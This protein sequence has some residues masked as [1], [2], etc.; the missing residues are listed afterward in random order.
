MDILHLIKYSKSY[1]LLRRYTTF[2]HS[3]F[4][5]EICVINKEN[6]PDN[7]PVIFAPNHQN[8]LMD[9][10]AIICTLKK[11]P[12]FMARADIFKKKAI[13]NLLYFFKI[14]P[15]YRIRDGIDQLQNNDDSF[16]IAL[17]VL[18]NNNCV[19]IMP[20]GN[21]GDQRRLRPLK[22][23]LSRFALQVQEKFGKSNSLKIIPV[24][25]EYSHYKKFRSKILVIY[26]N[27]IE[28]ADFM[29]IYMQSPQKAMNLLRD[30]LNEEMKSNIIN[31]DTD[32]YYDLVCILTDMY[33]N[34]LKIKL[35]AGNSF[36]EEYQV[37]KIISDK[38]VSISKT[39]QE[40]LEILLPIVNEYRSGL[41]KLHLSDEVFDMGPFNHKN[42]Y[43]D[44]I[45]YSFFLPFAVVGTLFHFLPG[46]I[47]NFLSGRVK[48]SQFQSSVKFVLYMILFPLYYIIVF[49][50]RIP[51]YTKIIV[52]LLMPVLG[53]LSFDYAIALKRCWY[54]RRYYN[55]RKGNS[56]ELNRMTELRSKIIR[57]MDA[58]I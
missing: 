56:S 14:I 17:Q 7:G 44:I 23:G 8:A 10:L 36:Y 32:N 31:I 18:K 48:D 35:E 27:P 38:L 20:E 21:H 46:I 9:A 2:W 6:V 15:V 57:K 30:R 43:F 13:G 41:K 26:D 16:N 29:E 19:G 22:K 24:G 4:Y 5:V 52:L 3:L 40:H 28:V 34:T 33:L 50:L 54:R 37:K 58:I 55:F 39:D 25:I 51:I 53:I 47:I 1:E 49:A 45:R 42:L 12:V 11:Q